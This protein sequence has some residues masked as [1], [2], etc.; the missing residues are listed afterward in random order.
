MICPVCA[1]NKDDI[2]S[3]EDFA[4]AWLAACPHSACGDCVRQ[5]VELQVPRCRD[6]RLLR[7][8]CF[9]P[10]CRK[11]LCQG[12]ILKVSAH[13]RS[14]ADQLERRFALETNRFIPA[15]FQVECPK[16]DCVGLGYLGF[17][18]AMCFVCE[19][20]W[21]VQARVPDVTATTTVGKCTSDEGAVKQCPR[22]GVFIEKDGGCDHVTCQCGYD[23]LWSTLEAWDP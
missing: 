3:N 23:F 20:Q 10:G 14:L 6:T 5:W 17:D 8:R 4:G 9:H 11:S 13:A 22:C 18:T 2:S 7:V 19:H 1:Q 15:A 16:K 21:R 12:W